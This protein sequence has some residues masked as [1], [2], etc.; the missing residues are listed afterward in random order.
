MVRVTEKLD[1]PIPSFILHRRLLIEMKTKNERHELTIS[2]VDEDTMPVTFL[3]SVR[4][5]YNRRH[6]R[7]GSFVIEFCL[8]LEPDTELKL[9]VEFMDTTTSRIW[10]LHMS[11]VT[12]QMRGLCIFLRTTRCL[13]NG[14]PRGGMKRV[15]ILSSI[16]RTTLP[17]S[18]KLFL[19][20]LFN[21]YEHTAWDL[22]G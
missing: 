11:M 1:L 4:L 18:V 8:S 17:S 13:A 3:Q 19:A 16:L 10:E 21:R 22:W 15:T 12:K 20:L 7:S 5:A 9:E 6:I 2:G 14:R